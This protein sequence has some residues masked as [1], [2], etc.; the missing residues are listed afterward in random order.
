[1]GRY[2]TKKKPEK[3]KTLNAVA[4]NRDVA[5]FLNIILFTF[6]IDLSGLLFGV[7]H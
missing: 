3:H 4:L 6:P 5:A 2:K 7:E 1:M